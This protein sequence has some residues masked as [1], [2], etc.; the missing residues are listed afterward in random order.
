MKVRD[1]LAENE[2]HKDP[3]TAYMYTI[4]Y[5][6]ERHAVGKHSEQELRASD[7]SFNQFV[8][9]EIADLKKTHE[10]SPEHYGQ[11][12]TKIGKSYVWVGWQL[13]H[14]KNE[15]EGDPDGSY[16]Y[17]SGH[18]D[19]TILSTHELKPNDIT[20]LAKQA[21]KDIDDTAEYELGQQ[22]DSDEYHRDPYSY[23]GV[24]RS[25]FMGRM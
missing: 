10:R 19:I 17:R 21:E 23:H 18:A 15:V 13:H 6:L 3:I 25:D 14:V 20:K 5:N 1:I 4:D 2:D 9:H 24:A 22:H 8:A 12:H 16:S 7:G 11:E